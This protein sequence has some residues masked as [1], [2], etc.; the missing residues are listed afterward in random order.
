MLVP[1]TIPDGS[2]SCLNDVGSEVGG[3]PGKYIQARLRNEG[4]VVSILNHR[5]GFGCM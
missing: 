1:W 5:P 4:A 3:G 2:E